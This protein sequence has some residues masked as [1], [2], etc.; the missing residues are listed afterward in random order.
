M[1]LFSSSKKVYVASSVNRMSEPIGSGN[2]SFMQQA[3]VSTALRGD[4]SQ[5]LGQSLV[6]AHLKGPRSSQRAFFRWAKNNFD[7]GMPRAAVS[8]AESIDHSVVAQAIVDDVFAS[9]PN[10]NVTI[11]TAAVD[12][13]D[14]IH[15][16]EQY[17][18]ENRPDSYDLD[19]VAD[20]DKATDM[21]WIQYPEGHDPISDS[22]SIPG[23]NSSDSVLVA[24]YNT[25]QDDGL[26]VYIY[27]IGGT[28]TALNSFHVGLS[29]GSD[30]REFYPFIPIR[31][32]NV[33]VFDNGSSAQSKEDEITEAYKKG[34]GGDIGDLITEINTNP[35]IDDIDYVYVAFG[36]CLN[37]TSR[38]GKRYIFEFMKTLADYQETTEADY[39]NFISGNNALGYHPSYDADG[40]EL[41]NTS[42]YVNDSDGGEGYL[43]G[44]GSSY[45]STLIAPKSTELHLKL[46]STTLGVLDMEISWVDITEKRVTGQAAPG[47]SVND[48]TV[49]LGG[50]YDHQVEVNLGLRSF[51]RNAT[52]EQLFVRKQVNS[53][54]YI[55]IV[56][57]QLLHKNMIYDGKSV[58]TTA[59][60]AL[61]PDEDDDSAFFLPLHEPTLKRMGLMNSTEVARDS[62]LLVINSY[63]VVK[64]K[65]YQKGFFKVFIVVAVITAIVVLAVV[66][67]GASLGPSAPILGGVLGSSAAIGAALGFSGLLALA[68][69]TAVNVLAAMLI[70][71]LVSVVATEVLGEK[72]G[73]IVSIV[74]AVA[75]AM[76]GGNFDFSNIG[77]NLAS[78][79]SMDKLLMLTDSASQIAGVYQ[80]AE[81]DKITDKLA[82]ITEQHDEEIDRLKEQ[83]EALGFGGGIID[84]MMLTDFT[85]NPMGAGFT[86]NGFED[87]AAFLNRTLMT[88]SDL[89]E[90]SE[91]M[92]YDFSELMLT[93]P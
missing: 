17:I 7:F 57:T 50:G 74:V 53:Q 84:P 89:I 2:P 56:A 69:G 15:Y 51:L 21:I 59:V 81:I 76:T 29:D 28:N 79:G 40:N 35:D 62:L 46:P 1:G 49:S 91:N 71:Q 10:V 13:V 85:D 8:Y 18:L 48:V 38:F 32:D 23:Y 25:D 78:M 20:Y 44:A 47:I 30:T 42:A 68:V 16:A 33:S 9:D 39:N 66:T 82:D 52:T 5:S 75:M 58:D 92:I 77:S 65:W 41:P 55:E 93:L 70:T 43:S 27:K 67:G 45:A 14:E 80:Q 31:I 11:V 3:L 6:D 88:G 22:F 37:D 24:Y 60:D 61:G 90:M 19:W 73:K 87:A 83:Y 26:Y 34:V 54:E 72:L 63:K 86:P 36:V 64:K 12:K 4:P